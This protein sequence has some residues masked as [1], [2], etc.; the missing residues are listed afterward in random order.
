MLVLKL[1]SLSETLSS[2]WTLQDR[3]SNWDFRDEKSS[4][5]VTTWDFVKF[6]TL[7]QEIILYPLYFV[8]SWGWEICNKL[9]CLLTAR[10]NRDGCSNRWILAVANIAPAP[11]GGLVARGDLV[12][13]QAGS[14]ST[15]GTAPWLPFSPPRPHWWIHSFPSACL[16]SLTLNNSLLGIQFEEFGN[17]LGSRTALRL[18]GKMPPL[19][20]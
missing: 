5:E 3:I 16:P 12:T 9:A 15:G 10:I 8:Y 6:L 17:L 13:P 20:W 7:F 1:S 4:K 2:C 11:L 18:V 14:I 19:F